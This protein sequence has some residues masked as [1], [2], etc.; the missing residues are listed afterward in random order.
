MLN[1][2]E[3]C[4]A[5]GAAMLV[6]KGIA[7]TQSD[8][9]FVPRVFQNAKKQSIP[10]RL[11]VPQAGDKQ[12]RY[13]MVLW[14]HGAAGRGSDNLKQITGGNAIGTHIWTTTENQSK[15]PCFVIAPQCPEDETWATANELKPAVALQLALELLHELQ[16]TFSLDL[17]RVYLAGQSMGGFGTWS[18]IST[19][20]ELFAA[21]IPLCGGGN[22][23]AAS[24]LTRT[25]IWAFHGDQD[26]SVNV[27]RS[28]TMIAAIRQAGGNPKYT[29]YKDVGHAVW[30][31]AF[32]E[33]GL[34]PWVFA[35]KKSA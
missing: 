18:A 6:P 25:P 5:V 17:Q 13:P 31:K 27:R 10:Y 4:L 32:R 15:N 30:E 16:S 9:V 28:R 20:P 26:E 2:R 34:L 7:A 21:A 24:K 1:R 3:F 29:E 14:L 8:E 22:E 35:Q 19:H 23:A 11:F 33:P 12:K